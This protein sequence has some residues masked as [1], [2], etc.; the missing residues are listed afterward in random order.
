MLMQSERNP[1]RQPNLVDWFAAP[2]PAL[3]N[4]YGRYY[5][6]RKAPACLL[7]LLCIN[8]HHYATPIGCSVTHGA[9]TSLAAAD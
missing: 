6:T 5:W 9:A 8:I 7:T 3:P 1:N 4:K 2:R